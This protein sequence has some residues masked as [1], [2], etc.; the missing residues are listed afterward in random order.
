MGH[1]VGFCHSLTHDWIMA[2]ILP[3]RD[4]MDN[5]RMCAHYTWF[6]LSRET[7]SSWKPLFYGS[8]NFPFMFVYTPVT[9]FFCGIQTTCVRF[10]RA[11]T[12]L[13]C[14]FRIDF[15]GP[16]RKNDTVS[17]LRKW[18][19]KKCLEI[20]LLIQYQPFYSSYMYTKTLRVNSAYGMIQ[21][22]I[23]KLTKIKLQ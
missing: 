11:R 9:I 1:H 4:T 2:D 19:K 17:F 12:C 6:Q 22:A 23:S 7:L 10:V 13:H 18:N 15:T 21:K 3:P 16:W 5:H 20:Y 14:H 8:F